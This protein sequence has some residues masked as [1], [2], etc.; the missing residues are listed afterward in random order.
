MNFGE[1]IEALKQ[2]KKVTRKGWLRLNKPPLVPPFPAYIP[3]QRVE[4]NQEYDL[5]YILLSDGNIAVCD[6]DMYEEV[7]K[8]NWTSYKGRYAMITDNT[9]SP[10]KTIKLQNFIMPFREGYV[11]DHINGN[12]LDCRSINMRYASSKENCRNRTSQNH[13]TSQYLGVSFDNSRDCWIASI[14][15]EGQTKHLGRYDSEKEAAEAYDKA[16][17]ENYGEF[18]RLNFPNS[19]IKGVTPFLWLK[20]ATV[21]KAEWCKDPLLHEL[22]ESNGGEILGLGTICMFTHDSTGRKAILTGWLASQSDMLSE[23]WNLVE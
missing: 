2:G 20:P 13:S 9:S 17:V 4:Y 1:A 16:A 3:K 5:T 19:Y 22:A 18:A 21:I 10:R 14:Q 12:G 15:V 23:D 11:I 7:V 6:G 8:H